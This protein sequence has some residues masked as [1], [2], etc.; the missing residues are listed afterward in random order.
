MPS[1]TCRGCGPPSAS[2][3]DGSSVIS[4]LNATAEVLAG[5][6]ECGALLRQVDWAKTPLGP[7]ET[8]P[9]SLRT[10]L[11]ILLSSRQPMFMWWGPE[12]VQ[13]Y[14][15]AYR[16]S[17]GD[18][19]HPSALGQRGEECWR[20]IWP[21]IGPLVQGVMTEGRATW[22]EDQLVPIPQ[23]GALRELFWT[24][25]YSPIREESGRIGGTFVTCTETTQRVLGERR[26]RTLRDLAVRAPEQ[27]SDKAAVEMAARVLSSNPADIPFC[28]LYLLEPDGQ[29]AVLEGL[30][31]LE[32]SSPVAPARVKLAAAPWPLLEVLS[33]RQVAVA[34]EV[35]QHFPGLRAGPW[36]EALTTAVVVPISQPGREEL[37]GFMLAGV[38]P[39]LKL[40]EAYSSFLGLVA[41]QVGVSVAH[42]RAQ[43]ETRRRMEALAELDRAKT[44]FFSNVSHELRTPL[45]LILGPVEDRLANTQEPLPPREHAWVELVR[46]NAQ[47]LEKLVN[48][49][50]EFARHE[51]GRARATFQPMDLAALTREFA[52]LFESA[53]QRA[54]LS[55]TVD[56]PPLPETVWVDPEAWEKIV[57]NLVSNAVKYTHT[58]GITVRL[59]TAGATV[60]L[61]VEDTGEGIPP[62]ELPHVFERFYRVR[63]AFSRSHEGSGIGLALVRELARM[64]GGGVSVESQ[65]GQGSRFTV[66]VPLGKAHLPADALAAETPVGHGPPG[67][68]ARAYVEEALRWTPTPEDTPPPRPVTAGARARILLADDNADLRRYV[69]GLL[70]SAFDVE[71]VADGREALQA[72]RA[73]RPDLVLSDVMM[74]GLDGFGLLRELRQDAALRAIPFILLSARAGEE[75]AVEGFEAGAD[76]YLVKP[77]S[78]RELLALVKSNLRLARMRQEI[79]RREALESSLQEALRAR[80]LAEEANRL[81]DEFLSTVSH[82][83]RTPLTAILGW[84]QML[85]TGNLPPEKYARALATVERNARAQAQLIE[86]LLDVSRIMSGK[87]K[88]EV[89]PVD[90]CLVVEAA[91]DTVRPAAEAKGIR[92]QTALDSTGRV[93]GDAHR[94]QQ[95]VW[96]LLSNAVK[97]TPKGGRVQVLVERRDSS[98]EITV[99]DTGPGISSDFLPHVFDRFRQ[100]DASSTRKHGGL[101]LGLSIVR[102]L[103]ELHGGGVQVFSEEG[104]G[105]SFVVRLPISVASRKEVVLPPPRSAGAPGEDIQCAPQLAGLR[106]LIVDDEEDSREYLRTLLEGCK[107]SV[108][109]AACVA[110]GFEVLKRERPDILVSDIG[111][112]E[113]D[114][115]AFIRKVRALSR[116]A[117]GRTPAVALTAYARVEDRTRVLLAGF[118]S[119]VPKPVEPVELLAVLASLARA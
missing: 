79:G 70:A 108:L 90:M 69:S 28:A 101:G 54:G 71:A 12:L 106:I 41:D 51:E 21:I 67:S 40:D 75:S 1:L 111:M 59:L 6:G 16:P 46:R 38:S 42:A 99:A 81:K 50:L 72:I 112:P 83:L 102:Q 80:A 8:W 24:F 116:E 113:E 87:L 17:L 73:R 14:N 39:R 103:V 4:H 25:G 15:D 34:T 33:T 92:L 27:T 88:L 107:A 9:Q 110:E 100:A 96:N 97:F 37:A 64:H 57:L 114:G 53:A 31:G 74:P 58:G 98:V 52:S 93:M 49:L 118:Q 10:V 30:S 77:F 105:A 44:A 62:E 117:G 84:V 18:D 94:L 61:E 104:K 85:K 3:E 95:V 68:T 36:P 115:Y 66:R 35:Q 11:S 23:D 2:K 20:E 78:A 86:D 55:L 89:E 82:E 7:V 5:G 76:D 43:A 29:S 26:L 32:P 91:L 60:L 109:A 65:P 56:C 19:K 47:R 45:T 48:T 13:F 119:H 63:G 22:A